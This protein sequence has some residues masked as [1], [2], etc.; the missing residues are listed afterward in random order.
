MPDTFDKVSAGQ[1]VEIPAAT[2]NALLEA[3]QAFRR[4][5][6][7]REG[8]STPQF[9]PT[10]SLEILVRND[11]GSSLPI[12]SVVALGTPVISAVDYPQEVR[13][14]PV[15]PG[16][17]PAAT[18]DNFAV[19]IEPAAADAYVRA[20]VM[21][22]V[23]ANLN[24]TDSTHTC[25][26]PAAG[27]TATLATATDGPAR[28]LWKESGTGTK[29]AVVLVGRDTAAAAAS[30]SD[31]FFARL[32][33]TSGG[34]WK[35]Y[36]QKV[37]SSN[38]FVDDGTES[39]SFNA[40]PITLD[41]T[42]YFGTPATGMRVIMRASVTSGKYEFEP[43][44]YAAVSIPGIVSATTQSFSG[45]K[46]FKSVVTIDNAGTVPSLGL[47]YTYGLQA[48]GAIQAGEY[49]VLS[50]S[51]A[52]ALVIDGSGDSTTGAT[53][54]V[55]NIYSLAPS[56]TYVGKFGAGDDLFGAGETG[57]HFD[58]GNFYVTGSRYAIQRGGGWQLGGT[59]T[60]AGLTFAGG[61]YISG[62]ITGTLPTPPPTGTYTLQSV[63]GV[64]QWV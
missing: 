18:T 56:S 22:V 1:P 7:G 57:F 9:S 53:G 6:L 26:G 36:R 59:A 4:Q 11:V 17:A 23:P 12:W 15:F 63:D 39:A 64:V 49:F 25:A 50:T 34:L 27:V 54:C 16:T 58:G 10:A 3:G 21:G 41:G 20:V 24:V 14:L 40:V 47:G 13:R 28:I 62:S 33:T 30:G 38:V 19:L 5:R 42:L 60:T 32:T 48:S 2:W 45:A 43:F 51:S 44:G 35:W 8:D 55:F 46:T 29:R 37:N 31:V 61:L 52:V